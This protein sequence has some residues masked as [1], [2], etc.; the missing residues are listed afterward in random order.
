MNKKD[1][2]K[3]TRTALIIDDENDICFLL[4]NILRKNDLKVNYV[5]SLAD[6][7]ESLKTIEPSVLFLD[8]YLPDGF[9]MDFITYVKREHA[10]TKIVMVTAHDTPEDRKNALQK[11]VNIFIAKPFTPDQINIALQNL[12]AE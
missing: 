1:K 7:I 12:D 9:G 6:G 3:V 5:H 4:S 10:A 2:L 11:G 8:N